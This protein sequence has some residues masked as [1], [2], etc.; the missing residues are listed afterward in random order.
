MER[1]EL[2]ELHEEL[3]EKAHEIIKKKN[4]D[5]SK[6]SALANFYVCEALQAASPVNGIV[7]RLS[8]KISRIVSITEKG[9]QVEDESIEDTIIDMINYSV[10]LAAVIK[11]RKRKDE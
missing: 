7:V 9:S 10:L 5:Y 4:E 6:G 2:Y 11:D 8:D 1:K 3:C